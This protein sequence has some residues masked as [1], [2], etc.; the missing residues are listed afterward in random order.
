MS[1][2]LMRTSVSFKYMYVLYSSYN[3]DLD[4]SKFPYQQ[5]FIKCQ[6]NSVFEQLTWEEKEVD[7]VG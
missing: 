3:F 7:E 5:K 2:T 1:V 6:C 4:I